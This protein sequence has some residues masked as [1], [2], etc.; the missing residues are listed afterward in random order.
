[1]LG[2]HTLEFGSVQNVQQW[3]QNRALWNTEQQWSSC[4]Q[5]ASIGN[6]LCTIGQE[7][8]DPPQH[9]VSQTEHVLQPLQKKIVIDA[10]KR[11]GEVQEAKQS[12]I[13]NVN[14]NN[15]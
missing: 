10:V 9:N 11:C 4:R 3:P 2:D 8:M 6:L 15:Y 14:N 13:M 12:N 7:W 5:L 1:M